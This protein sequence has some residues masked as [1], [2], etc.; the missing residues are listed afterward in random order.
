MTSTP[1]EVSAAVA[2][3]AARSIPG[4]R[5]YL[6]L[7]LGIVTIS[8]NGIFVQIADTHGDV[9]GFYRLFVGTL[10][11]TALMGI[12]QRR[13]R[14]RLPRPA[15]WLA[16][17]AGVFI[18]LD[19]GMW[20]TSVTLIGAGMAT[21]LGNTAPLWVALGAWLIFH[22][23][24]RPLYWVGLG[25]A[26]T[27]AVLI[28]GLDALQGLSRGIGN[29]LGL[30]TGLAYAAYQLL[31]SRARIHIDTISY[32]WVYSAVGAAI[33]LAVSLA[34]G[35][36]LLGLSGRTYAALIAM[37]LIS[38]IGGWMLVN[39]A[40]GHF[41]ASL[42]TTALLGQPVITTLLEVLIFKTRLQVWQIAGG[43]I[44]LAGIYLVHRQRPTLAAD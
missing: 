4:A 42:I 18:A 7:V 10:G 28:V 21:V 23:N 17:L 34:L 32:M 20:N 41:R 30:G 33:L 6:A 25:V 19:F 31:T 40:F 24:L 1:A 22:E 39:Y 11:L 8:L 5:A 44:V 35:H 12:N 29:L 14:M 16:V 26:L 43:A 36:P 38:H 2:A 27:G 9:A 13:G 3:P 37:G 15:L